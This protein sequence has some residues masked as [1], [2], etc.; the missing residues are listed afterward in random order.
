MATR[1]SVKTAPAVLA[2]LGRL[3]PHKVAICGFPHSNTTLSQLK[4]LVR[5]SNKWKSREL[6]Q[7]TLMMYICL[8]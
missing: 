2:G 8:Y 4:V 5:L 6:V 7:N 3:P 1:P